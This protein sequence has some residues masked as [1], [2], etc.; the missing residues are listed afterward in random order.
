[1]KLESDIG[2]TDCTANAVIGCTRISPGCASCYAFRDTPARVLRSRGVETWGPR[3]ERHVVKGFA[4]KLA[5]LNKLSICDACRAKDFARNLGMG[6]S[7]GCGGSN[8]RIRCF[9]DSNSDWLDDRWPL[10]TLAAFLDAI[11]LAPNVTVQ[12]LTKRLENFSARLLTAWEPPDRTVNAPLSCWLQGWLCGNAPTNV[13]LGVSVEDQKRADERIPKLLSIPAAVRFLSV[14]P[15]LESVDLS[16]W[17]AAGTNCWYQSV[18]PDEDGHRGD[19]P[20]G[21]TGINPPFDWLIVGGESGPD[22]RPVPVEAVVSVAEQCRVAGIPVWCTQDC[23]RKPGC[24]GRI[25]DDIWR[26]KELP[27]VPDQLRLSGRQPSEHHEP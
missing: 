24:Q 13:W 6:C 15:L 25:L 8:R 19:C 12:L 18:G 17:L 3:G 9:A 14:E 5:Q 4:A 20:C 1:V 22:F 26:L 2:W 16:A 21:G 23:G 7:R 11:R 10:E 27:S